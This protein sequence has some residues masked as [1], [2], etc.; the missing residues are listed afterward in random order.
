MSRE[1]AAGV[2]LGLAVAVALAASVGVLVMR[3]AYRKLHYL[4]LLSIVAPVLIAVAVQ[5]Q[6]G[7]ST[8]A[9]QTWAAVLLLAIASPVLSHAT[10]RAARIRA[11]G[12]WRGPG[13]PDRR[14][15][16]GGS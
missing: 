5:I 11:D 13:R 7:W 4:T 12:D 2:L 8:R 16:P 10:I 3:G 6:V 9:A 1:I 14:T 15:D